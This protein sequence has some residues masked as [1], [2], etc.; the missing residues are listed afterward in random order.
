MASNLLV[1]AS[2]LI[3]M[4]S[5]LIAKG[6]HS[7][8]K[9]CERMKGTNRWRSVVLD[10]RVVN[11]SVCSCWQ[12]LIALRLWGVRKLLNDALRGETLVVVRKVRPSMV[13]TTL[14]EIKTYPAFKPPSNN[15]T[16]YIVPVHVSSLVSQVSWQ[17]SLQ[18]HMFAPVVAVLWG[19]RFMITILLLP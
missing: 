5:N 8:L 2:N 10:S 17:A 12:H 13:C 4:A 19:A 1:M 6:T 3:G 15:I 18:E 16:S 11:L 7:S 9:I 14:D